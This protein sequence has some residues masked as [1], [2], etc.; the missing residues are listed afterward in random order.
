MIW[1]VCKFVN[2][3][4][5]ISCNVLCYPLSHSFMYT[6]TMKSN[7]ME[8][9]GIMA[10]VLQS[11]E[12]RSSRYLYCMWRCGESEVC[13]CEKVNTPHHAHSM[14]VPMLV[15]SIVWWGVVG[16]RGNHEKIAHGQLLSIR[17]PRTKVGS[18]SQCT[19][20]YDYYFE[21]A[22]SCI[23]CMYLESTEWWCLLNLHCSFYAMN[24]LRF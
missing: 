4:W 3:I 24:T 20:Y 10:T 15:I 9:N 17:I 14:L 19:C 6:N 5:T 23:T 7:R 1:Y 18:S 13:E 8:W 22:P 21:P 2:P 12:S 16:L 11:G